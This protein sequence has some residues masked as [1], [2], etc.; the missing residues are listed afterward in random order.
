MKKELLSA[1]L[2]IAWTRHLTGFTSISQWISPWREKRDTYKCKCCI[3]PGPIRIT[4]FWPLCWRG[5]QATVRQIHRI[6]VPKKRRPRF[7][8]LRWQAC[9]RT[10]GST[11][12]DSSPKQT[13]LLMKIEGSVCAPER[14]DSMTHVGGKQ[15]V[16]SARTC[17]AIAAQADSGFHCKTCFS[18]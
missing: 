12:I 14:E 10:Q 18:D 7:P 13:E 5:L 8:F 1:S 3:Q 4:D 15:T 6:L 17:R 2:L 9:L 11:K 16:P